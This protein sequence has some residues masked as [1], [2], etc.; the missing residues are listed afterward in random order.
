MIKWLALALFCPTLALGLE[1]HNDTFRDAFHP[2]EMLEDYF[3]EMMR[4]QPQV[5]LEGEA[6]A[7]YQREMRQKVLASLGLWPLPER[8]PLDARLSE[9]LEHEWCTVRRVA[10]QIWPGVYVEG[11][12]YT[13]KTRRENP[14]PAVLCPHG[15]WERGNANPDVQARCLTLAGPQYGYTVFS[16]ALHH[17]EDLNIGVVHKGVQGWACMRGLD[18]LASL[19]NVDPARL[20]CCGCSGGGAQTQELS[21]L[22]PRVKAAVI[23][24]LTCNSVEIS[25]PKSTHCN[26]NY[27]PRGAA[28]T[29]YVNLATM[30][31]PARAL[32]IT[33][34]D[35]T[36]TFERNNFPAIH[37][38]Y[39][40][41]GLPDGVR[42]YY[43]PTKH[44]YN[45]S[46]REQT[47]WWLNRTLSK[48]PEKAP[49]PEAQDL[50]TFPP[51]ALEG[52]DAGLKSN[53]GYPG[54]SAHYLRQFAGS[55]AA[56]PMKKEL[57]LL[58]GMDRELPPRLTQLE[59]ITT[60][61]H[62]GLR[63]ERMNCPSEGGL[64]LPLLLVRKQADST[65]RSV[66]VM[67]DGRGKSA[68][69]G[70]TGKG[71]ARHYANQGALVVL[72]DLRFSGELTLENREKHLPNAWRRAAI[73]WG[74]PF[75]GMAC[76]DLRHVLDKLLEVPGLD[77]P[78]VRVIA[79]HSPLLASAALFAAIVDP[80]ISEVDAD[81]M[82][83]SFALQ[84]GD[85]SYPL[86]EIPFVLRHGDVPQWKE[87]C[88]TARITLR[89]LP[90]QPVSK[91]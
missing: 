75:A 17:Y 36:R 32:F 53:L 37:E 86:P 61:E 42:C 50:H 46:K 64:R 29:D 40:R 84:Q 9:P 55:S 34:N 24:G 51:E 1:L 82:G 70:E 66:V 11:L 41:N 77:Q 65:P 47:Y 48:A 91:Q 27:W 20:G 71:S 81:F 15:H 4:P 35:W 39:A 30:A 14:A 57:P 2:E 63:V 18:F 28:L 43:E 76:T 31:F 52:L 68:A 44:M 78:G 3:Y 54:I 22:D 25:Y 73:L 69:L 83:T 87:L 80:R 19:P 85:P 33:M 12:L 88:T 90:Q 56:E 45:R 62:D 59:P 26:C 7:N 74:R 8:I 6:L 89:N 60:S 79:R 38:L 67:L 23:A 10:Y 13:P 72:P 58:L 49:L 5:I 16:P 21:A